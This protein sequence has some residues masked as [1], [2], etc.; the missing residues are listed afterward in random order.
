MKS[1]VVISMMPVW[2]NIE[3]ANAITG[4]PVNR[5]RQ[6]FNIGKIRA[7]KMGTSDVSTTV[8]RIQDILDVLEEDFP[9]PGKYKLRD[10]PL[11]L[12]LA[13]ASNS[14]YNQDENQEKE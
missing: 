3:T 7:R 9:P 13:S 1:N 2:G 14:P 5:I 11:P 12:K 8:F 6:L 10:D 4:V